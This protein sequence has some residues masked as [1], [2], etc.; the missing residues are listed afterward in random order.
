MYIFIYTYTLHLYIYKKNIYMNIYICIYIY[1]YIYIHIFIYMYIYESAWQVMSVDQARITVDAWDS[2]PVQPAL[3]DGDGADQRTQD[4]SARRVELPGLLH[5][6]HRNG[7]WPVPNLNPEPWTLNPALWTLNPEP[8]IDE[9][10]PRTQHVSVSKV[11]WP[12][13]S[14]KYPRD[15]WN[16]AL[17]SR[18]RNDNSLFRLT[19]LNPLDSFLLQS[20]R[21]WTAD[22]AWQLRNSPRANQN[23]TAPTFCFRPRHSL[24]L[25]EL[26]WSHH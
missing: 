25:V 8:W 17:H 4:V 7:H 23:G 14:D 2:K 16:R 26:I 12:E 15:G 18:H 1:I 20:W 5:R 22:P 10:L 13:E 21:V 3:G 19:S 11:C 6:G 9:F 24:V